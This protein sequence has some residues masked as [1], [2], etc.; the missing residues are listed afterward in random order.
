MLHFSIK[1]LSAYNFAHTPCVSIAY[2]F[3]TTCS[4]TPMAWLYSWYQFLLCHPFPSSR[5]LHIY[6]YVRTS[7]SGLRRC[8]CVSL[9]LIRRARSGSCSVFVWVCVNAPTKP[10]TSFSEVP[11]SW[12]GIRKYVCIGMY[13]CMYVCMHVCMYACMHV[14]MYACMHVCMYACMHVCMY[15]CMHAVSYTHLTLPTILLV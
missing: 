3:S 13:V 7:F 4:D 12:H 5:F 11:F 15:A 2:S 8:V 14:R 9:I 1:Y 6:T 10:G